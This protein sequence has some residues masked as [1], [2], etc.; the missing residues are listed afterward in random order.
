MS[1]G[2]IPQNHNRT[3]RKRYPQS[4]RIKLPFINNNITI[5]IPTSLHIPSLLQ[6]FADLFLYLLGPVLVIVVFSLLSFLSYT[7]FTIIVPLLSPN[8]HLTLYALSHE[9]FVVFILINVIFNYVLCVMTKNYG[10]EKYERV[11]REL[12]K[13]TGFIYPETKEGRDEWRLKFRDIMLQRSRRVRDERGGLSRSRYGDL[14]G[15]GNGNNEALNENE[16]VNGNLMRGRY[17]LESGGG[18]TNAMT[19]INDN[20][21]VANDGQTADVHSNTTA[22]V[23]TTSIPSHNHHQSRKPIQRRNHTTTNSTKNTKHA[24]M[25]T[26]NTT[27]TGIHAAPPRPWM[28]LGPHDWGYCEKSKLPKPPRSHF[29]YVTRALVLNMDHFCPWMFN[30]GTY[31]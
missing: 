7:F 25:N 23:N 1:R 6:G 8:G 12:A 22:A 28:L 3:R 18:G 16:N 4:Y 9:V 10:D 27:A 24:T 20:I 21:A 19:M 26:N 2:A 31:K 30:V 15:N 11:V 5:R 14:N 17:D 13:V 29:D